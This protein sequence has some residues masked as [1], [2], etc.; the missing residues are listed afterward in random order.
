MADRNVE[1]LLIGGGLAS[2]NCARWLREAGGTGSVLVVG[3]EPEPPYD[4]PTLTKKYLAGEAQRSDAYFRPDEWW[5]ENDIELLT[6][7]SVTGLDAVAKTA[8]LSNGDA[9]AFGNALL[10][11]GANV[12][13]LR[14]E[15]GALDGLH[16]V[17]AF[18]N[19]D[20]IRDD[21][22][23][24]GKRVV[25]V[26]GS[27]IGCEAAA[28]LARVGCQ[29]TIVTMEQVPCERAFGPEVGAQ[30]ARELE[31]RGVAVHT[32]Q[33]LA[34]FAGEDGAT[35]GTVRSVHT[36]QGLTVD[37]DVVVIGVGV[38][39]DTTLAQKAGLTIGERGGVLC[40]A[41]LQTSAADIYAAGDVCEYDSPLHDGTVRVEHWDVAFRH[42]RTA[43][44][45]ML[46][47]PTVHEDVPY[48]WTDLGGFEIE[49]VGAATGW[50]EI[51]V[52]GSIEDR[53]L[54]AW[55]RKGGRVVQ[56]V[57]VNRPELLDEARELL[58]SAAR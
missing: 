16:Y 4:R 3:R 1:Y 37:A 31:S 13:R 34:G 51:E 46:G 58:R 42:G 29:C 8:Q 18:G 28:T 15:G 12:R 47:T 22:E 33:T 44:L 49:S 27:F 10:A 39:P 41:R 2:A 40:D 56:A 17:R 21:L 14:V 32:G 50:D 54:G 11:T 36:E 7:I 35:Q 30:I 25:C 57:A 53:D 5:G 9:V 55:Y 23:R 26:G 45:N 19:T 38:A 24:L 6:G 48:F 20:A 52:D 43:A